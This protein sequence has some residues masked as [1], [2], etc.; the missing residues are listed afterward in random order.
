MFGNWKRSKR[1]FN[2]GL[3][4]MVY[5][6][7][8]LEHKVNWSTYPTTTQFLLG[9]GKTAKGYFKHVHPGVRSNQRDF[10]ILEEETTRG[11]WPRLIK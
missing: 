7:L 10:G 6:K 4:A 9:I 11:Y 3:L 1:L 5:T 8:K 2:Y